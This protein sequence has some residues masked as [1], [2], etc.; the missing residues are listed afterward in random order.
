MPKISTAKPA[1]TGL[2][3]EGPDQAIR[4]NCKDG[5]FYSFDGKDEIKLPF[6]DLVIVA[7]EIVVGP[8]PPIDPEKIRD[9]DGPLRHHQ[10][11]GQKIPNLAKATDQ[12]IAQVIYDNLM[13][14]RGILWAF[15]TPS[16]YE[17]MRAMGLDHLINQR[18]LLTVNFHGVSVERPITGFASYNFNLASKG[19]R[20]FDTVTRLV[21]DDSHSSPSGDM[22]KGLF[23]QEVTDLPEGDILFL[24]EVKATIEDLGD[25]FEISS[26]WISQ[27]CLV[28]DNYFRDR[29]HI[30]VIK[31][32]HLRLGVIG[33]ALVYDDSSFVQQ[34][35]ALPSVA[36][37]PL[38]EGI[39]DSSEPS[40]VHLTE[41]IAF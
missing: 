33:D 18:L 12:E 4:I 14:V 29:D 28:L 34:P 24:D 17:A 21:F 22:L 19:L 10:G 30:P 39:E 8:L 15:I 9:K 31:K 36:S 2:L 26:S 1:V 5:S 11:P 20:P 35:L 27:Q 37:I 6:I 32:D 7:S 41:T 16:S 38:L 13:K 3:F 40:D 25:N 23:F